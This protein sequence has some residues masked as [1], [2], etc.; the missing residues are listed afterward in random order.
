MGRNGSY[1]KP[2]FPG[3]AAPPAG[4]NSS[5]PTGS[6]H[7]PPPDKTRARTGHFYFGNNRTF[8]IWLDIW[9]IF[10]LQNMGLFG[11]FAK[12]MADIFQLLE[13]GKVSRY[14]RSRKK[15]LQGGLIS[16]VTQRAAGK[17]VLFL[18]KHDY[19]AMLAFMK[20]LAQKHETSIY[21]FCLK[22]N[23][24]HLLLR[25]AQ[26]NLH[27]FFR[28]LCGRYARRFNV[29]YERKGHLF[30]GRFRQ[31]VISDEK[32]LLAA[33]LYIHLNPVRGGLVSDPRSTGILPAASTR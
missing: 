5:R 23:H 31:S 32:Y 4:G 7:F 17:D 22:P 8:L 10:G 30:G 1:G 3:E 24:L 15:L 29:R 19:L 28:D 26:D 13:D 21:A 33:S 11:R 12:P 27:L 2:K 16:H 20:E 6:F 25:P 18:D 14:F 9:R